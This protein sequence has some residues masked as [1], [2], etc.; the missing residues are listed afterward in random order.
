[1]LPPSIEIEEGFHLQV[2]GME[3]RKP[4]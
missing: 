4:R 1:M 2:G 3:M